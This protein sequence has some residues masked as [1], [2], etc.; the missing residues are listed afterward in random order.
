MR[1]SA[2]RKRLAGGYS[3]CDAQHVRTPQRQADIGGERRGTD[4][5][6]LQTHSTVDE[7]AKDLDEN[8][9]DEDEDD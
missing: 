7:A 1:L 2:Y 8:N 6:Q 9:L 5:S 4:L 3:K